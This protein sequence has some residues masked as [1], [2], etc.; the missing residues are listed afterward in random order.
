MS[1]GW[2]LVLFAV[3]ALAFGL[4]VRGPYYLNI[5][6]FIC[7]H[8]LVAL[9]LGL[10]MGG[11][12]QISLGHAGFYGLGAYASAILTTR[13]G[14]NPWLA[15]G[16]GA[17]ATGLVAALVGMPTL[18]L[19][20][21]Y[22]AMGTLGL[23]AIIQIVFNQAD[24]ITEG[25][26]GITAIPYLSIAG[27]P[28]STDHRFFFLVWPLLL[29]AMLLG[30]NLLDSRLGRALRAL[31][32][33][34]GAAAAAGVD[35]PRA[36]LAVF[37]LSAVFASVAGSLYAHYLTYVSPSPF[38]FAFSIQLLVMVILGGEKSL[39]GPLVGAGVL[40]VLHQVLAG[41]AHQ[42]PSFDGLETVAYGVILVLFLIFRPQGLAAPL[43]KPVSTSPPGP[44]PG[45]EREPVPQASSPAAEIAALP[46]DGSE[47]AAP[48]VKP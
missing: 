43:R 10:L 15:M 20:G 2:G 4:L 18:R 7:I 22:L 34:E 41:A 5:A 37:V 42:F 29:G 16:L 3:A 21:H 14:V 40:T 27:L 30:G 47:P 6:V 1:R 12:G 24:Q 36:K 28:L 13:W 32:E 31:G 46:S 48:G 23:G 38:G 8:G 45:A 35:V 17:L 25:P 33:N 19:R 44:F 9:G 11:A 39:W 26:S